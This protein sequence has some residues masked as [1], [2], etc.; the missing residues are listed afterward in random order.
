MSSTYELPVWA[1][2]RK[3]VTERGEPMTKQQIIRWFEQNYPEIKSTTVGT[4]IYTRC[5]QRARLGTGE[6][7]DILYRLPDGSYV[8]HDVEKH[9]KFDEHGH[10]LEAREVDE[11]PGITGRTWQLNRKLRWAKANQVIHSSLN[12]TFKEPLGR[13]YR[14]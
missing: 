2:L 11:G 14:N 13:T 3:C 1:L 8:A 12:E 7:H 9:G 5:V 4:H 6:K 10:L